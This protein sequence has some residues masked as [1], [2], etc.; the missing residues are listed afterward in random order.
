MPATPAKPTSTRT[1]CGAEWSGW[2]EVGGAV[3]NLT[4]RLFRHNGGAVIDFIDLRWWPVFNVADAAITC[5]AILLVLTG[6]RGE[7]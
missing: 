2:I 3:G 5:G 6:L 7:R 4:D 1:D